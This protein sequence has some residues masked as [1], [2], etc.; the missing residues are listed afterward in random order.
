M[1]TSMTIYVLLSACLIIFLI[2]SREKQRMPINLQA[3]H[4]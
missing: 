2:K 4:S 1:T 3:K